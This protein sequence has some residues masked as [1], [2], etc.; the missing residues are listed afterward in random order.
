M[1]PAEPPF[2]K[3]ISLTFST[4][5]IVVRLCFYVSTHKTNEH[6]SNLTRGAGLLKIMAPPMPIAG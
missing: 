5:G 1:A 6:P 3:A 2:L 4:P